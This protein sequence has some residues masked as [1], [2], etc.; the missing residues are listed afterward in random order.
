[1]SG[2]VDLWE[3][4]YQS[5]RRGPAHAGAYPGSSA[6]ARSNASS[7]TPDV[8][9]A[10]RLLELAAEQELVVCFRVVVVPARFGAGDAVAG[11]SA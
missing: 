3:R 8:L 9:L 4:M 5:D 10:Q 6:T 11:A 2:P 1:M 7:A